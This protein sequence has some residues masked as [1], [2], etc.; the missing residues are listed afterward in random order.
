MR[1][2]RYTVVVRGLDED[3]VERKISALKKKGWRRSSAAI[4]LLERKIPTTKRKPAGS[5]W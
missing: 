4:V 1:R 3:E 5:G 2:L